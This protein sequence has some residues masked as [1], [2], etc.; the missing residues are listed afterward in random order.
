LPKP[1]TILPTDYA[2]FFQSFQNTFYYTI[3]NAVRRIFL[4][5]EDNWLLIS[6][7]KIIPHSCL[8]ASLFLVS[9]YKKCPEIQANF[10]F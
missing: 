9:V 6:E 1:G 4:Y 8:I 3:K 5:N 10:Y 7:L 2:A